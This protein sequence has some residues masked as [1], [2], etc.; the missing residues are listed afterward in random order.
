MRIL[1][2]KD[3]DPASGNSD[4]EFLSWILIFIYPE[5]RVLGLATTKRGG[6]KVVVKP[7]FVAT[8]FTKFLII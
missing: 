5:S 4:P 1:D 7:F 3:S 2:G 6:Q 8:I